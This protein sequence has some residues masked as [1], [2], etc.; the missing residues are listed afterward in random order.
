MKC[1]RCGKTDSGCQTFAHQGIQCV[2]CE[3]CQHTVIIEAHIR[4]MDV[5]ELVQS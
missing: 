2:L 4:A 5:A 3:G 1:S